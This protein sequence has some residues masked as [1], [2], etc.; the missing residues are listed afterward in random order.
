[1]PSQL[2]AIIAVFVLWFAGLGAAAQFAK[3]AIPFQD[4]QDRFPDAGS[5][6]GW[7][8]SLVSLIGALFGV[9]AGSLVANLGAK[10]VLTFGLCLGALVSVWQATLPGFYFFLGSRLIEGFSHLAVVVAAPTMIVQ[11]ASARFRGPAMTLWSTF[12]GV[13]F[14]FVAWVGLPLTAPYGLE[15]LFVAHGIFLMSIAALIAIFI[16]PIAKG[17]SAIGRGRASPLEMHLR[18]YRSPWISAP[19][20]GWLFYTLT[21]VSLLA[22][23]PSKLP[24]Q[25]VA[26]T[27]GL[28]PI[29][30]IAS[31][32]LVVPLLLRIV[33]SVSIVQIGFALSAAVMLLNLFIDQ[34]AALAIAVFTTLGLVQGASF[35]AVPELN[36]QATEQA[37]AYGLL[38]QTGNVG[39]LLGTPL[40]LA[41]AAVA[42]NAGMYGSVAFL[43]GVGI[44]VHVALMRRRQAR[45]V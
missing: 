32:L 22:I 9:V 36:K 3:I 45:A 29:V 1:M 5:E 20:V 37:L 16:P 43:Y 6:L 13:A 30:S 2:R 10:H 4:I 31:A 41:I 18:A 15:T 11:I 8:L 35:S 17:G 21:F 33:S 26:L 25:H 38:A 24:S 23:I 42:G 7:L 28:M 14:A 27:V 40:L 39:N 12:F 44:L 34:P 19:G